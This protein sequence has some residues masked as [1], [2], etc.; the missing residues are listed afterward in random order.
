MGRLFYK[1]TNDYDVYATWTSE[2]CSQQECIGSIELECDYEENTSF[3]MM[4]DEL[5]ING[6]IY[7]LEVD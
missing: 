2:D 1:E 6:F 4:P 7:K 5:E 3:E